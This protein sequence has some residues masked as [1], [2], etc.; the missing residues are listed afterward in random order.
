MN[1]VATGAIESETSYIRSHAKYYIVYRYSSVPGAADNNN[2]GS[3]RRG[4]MVAA[5]T[6]TG[7]GLLLLVFSVSLAACSVTEIKPLTASDAKV[8][9][10]EDETRL[11]SESAKARKELTRRG[12]I[13][14]DPDLTA[15]LDSILER[16]QPEN[17]AGDLNI[18]VFVVRDPVV[19]AFAFPDGGIY[20]N[21]GLLERLE[22]EAQLALVLAHE[23][24]HI[25][26]RHSLSRYKDR[27]AK[28]IA[29]HITDLML[30]GT[31][32][33]YIPYMASISS[34][35]RAQEKEADK[36]A[37]RMMSA[38]DYPLSG[39]TDLFKVINEVKVEES[40]ST[41]IYSSHPNNRYRAE[42]TH[43]FIIKDNL[44]INS[45]SSDNAETYLTITH[46]L[47]PDSIKLRL[48][49]KHYELARDSADRAVLREPANPWFYYYR[50]EAYRLMGDDPNGTAREHAQLY[51]KTFSDSL[52]E[53]MAADRDN[54]YSDARTAYQT[55]LSLD[56]G[57][58]HAYRGIGLTAFAQGDYASSNEHLNYYLSHA[59]DIRDRRYINRILKNM[60]NKN[61]AIS[62]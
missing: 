50:G 27:K 7:K 18:Q 57:F 54:F 36:M 8:G 60:E 2:T 17:L 13:I 34:Y 15:Y 30:L 25:I 4:S 53:E 44:E 39:A 19:N 61:E 20:I 47:H 40:V 33:A 41:S 28:I 45:D 49:Y 38:A 32:I 10:D 14:D 3:Y 56:D 29:A 58:A 52:I 48:L 62:D 6:H 42:Y 23:L 43:K 31:S 35:S 24:A 21:I 11:F 22:N 9:L 5:L 51:N 1:S 46:S 37:L 16:L 59:E 55:A 26:L 12:L